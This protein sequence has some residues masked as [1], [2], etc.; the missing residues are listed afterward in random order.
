MYLPDGKLGYITRCNNDKAS[1]YENAGRTCKGAYE[2]VNDAY[3][4]YDVA[5]A[6]SKRNNKAR[7]TLMFSC[8]NASLTA[9]NPA[10][11]SIVPAPEVGKSD[12]TNSPK[13]AH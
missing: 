13:I 2:V 3:D 7:F 4:E 5:S 6:A 11:A 12:Q 10:A 1:C 9:G 8:K